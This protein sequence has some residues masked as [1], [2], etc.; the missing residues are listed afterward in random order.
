[1]YPSGQCDLCRFFELG[2]T[3]VPGQQLVDAVDR[4]ICNGLKHPCQIGLRVDTVELCCFQQSISD[5]G[6]FTTTLRSIVCARLQVLIHSAEEN[7]DPVILPFVC[8][9]SVRRQ[10]AIEALA[11]SGIY[12]IGDVLGAVA[13][14]DNLGEGDRAE[15][16]DA[17]MAMSRTSY[18]AASV[19][20]GGL[21][22]YIDTEDTRDMVQHILNGTKPPKSKY[23]DDVDCSDVADDPF[24]VK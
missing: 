13:R 24:Y 12:D 2:L 10:I 22:G 9:T 6:S 1:M 5:S 16:V 23:D 7:D 3:E 11:T 15:L 21:F 14:M 19:R 18:I 8:T 20:G 17:F 4:V